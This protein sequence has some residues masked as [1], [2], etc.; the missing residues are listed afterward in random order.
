MSL[1]ISKKFA[2]SQKVYS[3]LKKETSND[4]CDGDTCKLFKKICVWE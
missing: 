1:K 3:T 4:E 2:T